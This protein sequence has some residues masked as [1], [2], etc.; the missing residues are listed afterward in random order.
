[1]AKKKRKK[2]QKLYKYNKGGIVKEEI[3]RGCGKIMGNRRKVTK[4]N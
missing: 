4:Y 2:K 1:M 3:A